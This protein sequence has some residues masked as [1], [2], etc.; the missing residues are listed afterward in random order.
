MNDTTIIRRQ[1]LTYVTQKNDIVCPVDDTEFLEEFGSLCNALTYVRENS[2]KVYGLFYLTALF[3][4][5]EIPFFITFGLSLAFGAPL[6]GIISL[7]MGVSGV[8][9]MSL[10]KNRLLRCLALV[11][12]DGK[13][14]KLYCDEQKRS[15]NVVE[16]TQRHMV[17]K[18]F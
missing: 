5:A 16:S 8:L 11:S 17:Y 13:S 14:N 2:I 9:L 10:F 15:T 1:L 6:F 4:V 18:R 12:L 7:L 3:A